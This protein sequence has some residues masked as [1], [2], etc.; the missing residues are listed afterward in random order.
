MLAASAEAADVEAD[1]HNHAKHKSHQ[2]SKLAHKAKHH[3]KKDDAENEDLMN[4]LTDPNNDPLSDLI[5]A[6]PEDFEKLL[7]NN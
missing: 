7:T 2:K 3:H 4:V 5:N 1:A 6:S